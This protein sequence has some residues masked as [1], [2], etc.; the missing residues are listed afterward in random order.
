MTFYTQITAYY[1]KKVIRTL[2]LK[3]N[4][5]FRLKYPKNVVITLFCKRKRPIF[6]AEKWQK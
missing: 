5:E 4:D 6:F 2:L 3:E 1:S